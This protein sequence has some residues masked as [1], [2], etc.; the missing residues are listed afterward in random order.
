MEELLKMM[1]ARVTILKKALA[2]AEKE[3]DKAGGW[4]EG[5]LRISYGN[6]RVRFYHVTDT[7]NKTGE[8]I[9]KDRKKLAKMLANKDYNARFL[10]QAGFE[11]SRLETLIPQLENENGDLA[12]Q[13]LSVYRK[14]MISPYIMTNELYA[15]EW[16]EKKYRS[17]EYMSEHKVY[18]TRKGDMVRS[19]SEAIIADILFDLEIPYHYEK[20]ITL[21]T[22]EVR[23][24]DFTLLKVRT[25]EEIFLEHFGLWDDEDYR[26]NSMRKLAEYR[27]NGIFQGKNLLYTFETADTPLDIKGIKAM[28]RELFL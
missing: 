26:R 20:P 11:L 2:K 21:R 25:R 17:N 18:E 12:Y 1:K 23:Y 10:K 22:G 7:E 14:N 28:F 13:N 19:K 5:R 16:L 27:N 3:A 24:P 4:P 8:Y 6:K 15:K 9:K